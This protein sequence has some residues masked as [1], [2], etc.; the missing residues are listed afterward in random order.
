[1]ASEQLQALKDTIAAASARLIEELASGKSDQLV[2]YLSAMA[3]FRKYSFSNMM[4]I[5][6]QRPDATRVAGFNAWKKL[7]RHVIKGEKAIR[8]FAPMTV[9][10]RSSIHVVPEHGVSADGATPAKTLVF[11]RPV[12]VFAYEQTDGT[13]LPEYDLAAPTGDAS[14]HYPRLLSYVRE[15]GITVEFEEGIEAYGLSYGGRI[16]LRAGMSDVESFSV[17]VHETAHELLHKAD[18]RKETTKKIRETEAEAVA[19]V[20]CTALGIQ[21]PSSVDYIQLYNGDTDILMASLALIQKTAAILLAALLS[22]DSESASEE[23]DSESIASPIS[24]V[25]NDQAAHSMAA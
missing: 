13:P 4:L 19:Y 23:E 15:Q 10:D 21:A 8:I 2:Q 11:Y 20:V 25:H 6:G 22:G 16:V 18:R 9:R 24:H 12:P 5:L 3:R 1:M 14:A 7:G 17:L